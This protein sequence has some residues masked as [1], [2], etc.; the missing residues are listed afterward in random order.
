MSSVDIAGIS[1]LIAMPVFHDIP[2]ETARSLL[3]TQAVC[4]QRGIVVDIE[5]NVGSTV[6]HS[7]SKAAHRFL[8]SPCNRLFM[9]DSDMVWKGEDF[10]KF[11][12]LSAKMD[13]VCATYTARRDPPTFFVS[14]DLGEGLQANEYG[15]I[16]IDG[17][18]LGFTI[19]S[20]E[21]VQ[22]LADQAPK[23]TFDALPGERVPKIFRFDEPNGE[24][25]GED[26]AFFADV[27]A[28]GYPVMLDPSITLGHVGSKKFTANFADMLVPKEK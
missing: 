5:M 13:C 20:R 26:I 1:V 15:C 12:A 23:I 7:R 22:K 24:A 17:A 16:P 25:R 6:F 2:P 10:L 28:L 3:E 27:R 14:V 11:V 8:K 18:G 4:H 9:I 19:V 21:V